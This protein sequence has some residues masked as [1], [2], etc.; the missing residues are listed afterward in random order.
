MYA[1]TYAYIYSHYVLIYV[2]AYCTRMSYMHTY[3]RTMCS[4]VCIYMCI[5]RMHN[6][7]RM[8]MRVYSHYVLILRAY[9]T[10]M[11]PADPFGWEPTDLRSGFPPS[12]HPSELLRN[13]VGTREM[14]RISSVSRYAPSLSG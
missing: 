9:K 13:S 10:N 12:P 14:L 1:Y 7:L 8:G 11:D 6:P 4:Y 5:L 3:T 2:Y